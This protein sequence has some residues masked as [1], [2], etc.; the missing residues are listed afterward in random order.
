LAALR[1]D[2]LVFS[3]PLHLIRRFDTRKWDEWG[4]KKFRDRYAFCFLSFL[5][6]DTT[7]SSSWVCSLNLGG[8]SA[9][10]RRDE[11]LCAP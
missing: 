10:I 4:V 7:Q 3:V 11:L 5:K 2:E 1:S 8:K 9:N 6:V